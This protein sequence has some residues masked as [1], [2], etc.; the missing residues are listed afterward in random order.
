MANIE[1]AFL[2]WSGGKDAMMAYY[3]LYHCQELEI[4]FFLTTLNEAYRRI[5]MHGVRETLLDRQAQALGIPLKKVWL[6]E[7]ASMEIYNAAMEKA[8]REMQLQGI[9]TA[10][11]GD[12]FLEDL[13]TYR[14]QQLAQISMKAVFPL[15]KQDTR[16][17]LHRFVDAG[18]QAVIVCV[19]AQKL[20]RSFVGRIIDHELIKDLPA[21][22]DPCGENGEY[23]SFVFNGPLFRF[24]VRFQL[25]EVVE[26][27]LP[28]STNTHPAWDTVFWYVDLIPENEN[29]A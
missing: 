14:E 22:V 17:L 21:D 2:N 4:A 15:W 5:S 3:D 1:A 7:Q 12:I 23:H 8:L 25:G 29:G 26:R 24:P 20:D 18:F 28:I 10:I 9:R 6:P 16:T 27:R 11:F 19:N 13:R